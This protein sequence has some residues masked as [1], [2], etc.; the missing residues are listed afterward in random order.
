MDGI[1]YEAEPGSCSSIAGLAIG[2]VGLKA[3]AASAHLV[4]ASTLP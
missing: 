4:P 2:A 3:R 1:L